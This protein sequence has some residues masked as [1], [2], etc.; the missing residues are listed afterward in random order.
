[1]NPTLRPLDL[2]PF[3][4]RLVTALRNMPE[5]PVKQRIMA[6]LDRVVDFARNP[7]CAELQADGVPCGNAQGDCDHCEMVTGLLDELEQGL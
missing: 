2:D 6:L 3:E 7:R 5:S 4:H 1:M